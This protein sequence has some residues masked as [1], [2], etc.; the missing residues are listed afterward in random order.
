MDAISDVDPS[1]GCYYEP[2][3]LADEHLLAQDGLPASAL[4]PQFHQQMGLCGGDD[5]H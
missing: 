1:S 2:V 3:D 4:N 5:D